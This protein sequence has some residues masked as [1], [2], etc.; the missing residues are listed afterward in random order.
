MLKVAGR[1][2]KNYILLRVN[3]TLG[4]SIKVAGQ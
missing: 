1:L 3:Q 4:V 2:G